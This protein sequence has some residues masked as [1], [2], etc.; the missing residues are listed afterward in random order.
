M[1][2][3][4]K[5]A[6]KKIRSFLKRRQDIH[7]SNQAFLEGGRGFRIL[8]QKAIQRARQRQRKREYEVGWVKRRRG[9]GRSCGRGINMIKN[10]A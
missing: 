9:S 10:V 7:N 6:K 3:W 4:L 1:I 8:M 5:S 2:E